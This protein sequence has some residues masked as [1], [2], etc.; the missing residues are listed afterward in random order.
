M[1]ILLSVVPLDVRGSASHKLLIF[2]PLVGATLPCA[3]KLDED[4]TLMF[5]KKLMSRY[6]TMLKTFDNCPWKEIGKRKTC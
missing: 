1:G 2:G 3:K 5:C 4:F 6:L